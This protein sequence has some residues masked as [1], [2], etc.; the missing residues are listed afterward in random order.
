MPA[1]VLSSRAAFAACYLVG[2]C[3]AGCHSWR[4]L[5]L[6]MPLA[7]AAAFTIPVYTVRVRSG[8]ARYDAH[9]SPA[10]LTPGCQLFCCLTGVV[11]VPLPARRGD[12]ATIW[13][14][15]D[16]A[17]TAAAPGLLFCLQFW[18]RFCLL[19][20]RHWFL[21]YAHIAIFLLFIPMV[22][23]CAADVLR[24]HFLHSNTFSKF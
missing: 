6:D 24:P 19:L 14:T 18:Q 7:V 9:Q 16:A 15:A 1:R 4:V 17:C 2:R 13:R 3:F 11:M 12:G 10:V 8:T 20:P 21:Y 5:R 23:C 22:Y